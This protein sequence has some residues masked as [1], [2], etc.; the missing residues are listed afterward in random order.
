MD[1]RDRCCFHPPNYC[2]SKRACR[3]TFVVS[4]FPFFSATSALFLSIFLNSKIPRVF[5]GISAGFSMESP[6]ITLDTHLIYPNGDGLFH[7]ISLPLSLSWI[8]CWLSAEIV[9]FER[10]L[11]PKSLL[12]LS[13]KKHNVT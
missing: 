8:L 7:Y 4:Y 5:C 13:K 2:L 1:D 3:V 11:T 12:N 10:T 9:M 6:L